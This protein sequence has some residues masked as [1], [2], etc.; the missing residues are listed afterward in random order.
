MLRAEDQVKKLAAFTSVMLMATAE[1][2]AQENMARPTRRIVVSIPDR[3]LAVV[4]SGK[5]VKIFQTAVGAPESPS[6]T[7]VYQIVNTISDP[8]W[9][10]KGKVVPPGKNNPVGTRWLGL[11]LKGYGIHGTN[12]PASIGQNASHGCIRLRNRDIEELFGMVRIGDPV[13]LYGDRTPE[14]DQIFGA[15]TAAQAGAAVGTGASQ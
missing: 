2:L 4:E 5:V 6:P 12:M 1:A 15:V 13:E 11:S 7:G 10:S 8:T 3:K 9:Y 14:L